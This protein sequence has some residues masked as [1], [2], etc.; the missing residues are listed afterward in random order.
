MDITKKFLTGF[1]LL[2][3]AVGLPVG[4]TM[5]PPAEGGPLPGIRLAIPEDPV[6]R[7]YLGLQGQGSFT[8]PE[9]AADVVIVEIFSMY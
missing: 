9:I 1:L 5:T 3:T 6:H 2:V 8:I 4:A 7:N